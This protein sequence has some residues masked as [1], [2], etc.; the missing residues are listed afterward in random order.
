MNIA[1]VDDDIKCINEICEF[2]HNA[3]LFNKLLIDT[4][5]TGKSFLS[6]LEESYDIVFLD[7]EME[8]DGI[9]TAKK[10]RDKHTDSTTKIIF[11]SGYETYY[12]QLY[13]VKPI[14]FISK[15]IMIE[16]LESAINKC[17]KQFIFEKNNCLIFE[18]KIKNSINRIMQKD[19][20]YFE[21]K[22][23]KMRIVSASEDFEFYGRVA[24]TLEKLDDENFIKV[25]ESYIVNLDNVKLFLP[26]SLTMRNSDI[27]CISKTYRLA[28]KRSVK[29]Y[30]GWR[31][32]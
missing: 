13:E 26:D 11:V 18:Y 17:I 31:N 19:I 12:K 27:I 7:I 4:Y 30:L 16:E 23:R 24:E 3:K 10:I 22:K 32:Q 8:Y 15:P 21:S 5:T 1:V 9:K 6:S 28:V 14:A 29:R 2:L 20:F 25:H